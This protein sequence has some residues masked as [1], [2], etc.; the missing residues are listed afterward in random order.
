MNH[1][2]KFSFMVKSMRVARGALLSFRGE[3]LYHYNTYLD[4]IQRPPVPFLD[5]TLKTVIKH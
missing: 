2:L 3:M 4:R 1:R 5:G